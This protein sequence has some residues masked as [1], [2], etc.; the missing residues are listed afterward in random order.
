MRHAFLESMSAALVERGVATL[1]YQFPYMEVGS[2][3]PNP[4]TLLETTVR[5]AVSLAG[6]AAPGL[7]LIAG[8]KSLGGRMTSRAASESPLKGVLGLAF[9][10]FPL[11]A[12]GKPG[13]DRA[14]HLDRV[15]VPM[16]F[17]QGT[18]DEFAHLDLLQSV[19]RELGDRATLRLIEGGDHSFKVLKRSGRKES[20]VLAE[21]SDALASWARALVA[22]MVRA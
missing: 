15:D 18:R 13:T 4:P 1:R 21:L 8:G 20:D 10:G 7:P 17:L 16:L 3:R 2:R 11:H 12:P 19:C 6:G 5:A 9:L 22:H 14:A